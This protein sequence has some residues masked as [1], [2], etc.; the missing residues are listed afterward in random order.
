MT[1]L[2]L[3]RVRYD[4]EGWGVIDSGVTAGDAV[5]GNRVALDGGVRRDW[6]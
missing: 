4:A 5:S 6:G 3:V 1:S 2:G